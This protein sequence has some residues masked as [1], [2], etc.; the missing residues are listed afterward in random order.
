MQIQAI[1][2]FS[3]IKTNQNPQFKSVYPVYHWVAE[4]NGSYAPAVTKELSETL[5]RKII[6]FLNRGK[7][8]TNPIKLALMDYIELISRENSTSLQGNTKIHLYAIRK[9]F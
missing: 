6:R 1:N 8:I 5:Q 9:T 2:S 7:S 4:A 3:N